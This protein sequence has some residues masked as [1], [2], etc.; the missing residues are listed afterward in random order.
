MTDMTCYADILTFTNFYLTADVFVYL[1]ERNDFDFGLFHLSNLDTL[2]V[3][4]DF[5]V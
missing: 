2:N 5:S 4:Y 1:A 3:T